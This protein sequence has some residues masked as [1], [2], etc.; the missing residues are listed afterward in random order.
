MVK[1]LKIRGEVNK[2]YKSIALSLTP[3]NKEFIGTNVNAEIM[4]CYP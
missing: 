4:F 3:S 1:D 2:K